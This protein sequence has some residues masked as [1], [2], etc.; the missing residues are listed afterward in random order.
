MHPN[1]SPG[2][3]LG[4][5]IKAGMRYSGLCLIGDYERF[6]AGDFALNRIKTVPDKELYWDDEVIFPF[7]NVQDHNLRNMS[8]ATLPDDV[9]KL[10]AEMPL[11]V[12]PPPDVDPDTPDLNFYIT[13]RRIDKL[14]ETPGCRACVKRSAPGYLHTKVCR[15]RFYSKL[16]GDGYEF[17][18]RPSSKSV[19]DGVEY[20]VV[21]KST[22]EQ[23]ADFFKKLFLDDPDYQHIVKAEKAAKRKEK[24]QAQRQQADQ[25]IADEAA[26]FQAGSTARSSTG[27]MKPAPSPDSVNK[28]KVC[29]VAKIK[30]N[31]IPIVITKGITIAAKSL[32][33]G[34]T[35]IQTKK[36]RDYPWKL[37]RGH[38]V[39]K[40]IHV[41]P[42]FVFDQ[43][44]KT[45][46]VI[47]QN[48]S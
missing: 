22:E 28:S 34:K 20:D 17:R 48:K 24:R 32:A 25:L 40:K 29:S 15:Q 30:E 44:S 36:I 2:F 41:E 9:E 6:K 43:Y 16:Q 26:V 3:F 47:L 5:E 38:G 11:G 4:W 14:G 23:D 39:S 33:I 18:P 1:S 8:D 12:P 37:A 35:R 46:G 31:E 42:E 27:V 19:A 45:A 13:K 10:D 21:E 7:K